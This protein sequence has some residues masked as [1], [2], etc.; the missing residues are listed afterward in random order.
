MN[1]S[2]LECSTPKASGVLCALVIMELSFGAFFQQD[3]R[4]QSQTKK[5]YPAVRPDRAF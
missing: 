3:G 2:I 1:F 5:P 4:Y